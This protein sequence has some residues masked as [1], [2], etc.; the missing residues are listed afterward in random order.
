MQRLAVKCLDA[1]TQGDFS[2]LMS[3]PANNWCWCVAWEVPTWEGWSDRSAE[4]N[5]QLRETLWLQGQYDGYVIYSEQEP[6]GWVRVGPSSCWPKL[7]SS[8]GVEL[9]DSLYIITC[10]GI[11]PEH[12]GQ[13]HLRAGLMLV[14]DELRNNGVAE[15][16]AV[17]KRYDNKRVG[18]DKVWN[19][20]EQLYQQLGFRPVR[21]EEDYVEVRLSL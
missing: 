12:R 9:S 3:A 13:G 1:S 6:I 20:P 18:D 21:R 4:D 8:R 5:R 17:P 14:L 11:L 16:A 15:V 19:G 7:A 10:V 2:L